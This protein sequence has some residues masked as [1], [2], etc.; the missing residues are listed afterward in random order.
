MNLI[1][2]EIPLTQGKVAIVDVDDYEYLM[3]WSWCFD[4]DY[5]RRGTFR[6]GVLGSTH[7]RN[8]KNDSL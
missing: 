2:R 3:Q 7:L 6:D 4:G 1:E 8:S 5:A